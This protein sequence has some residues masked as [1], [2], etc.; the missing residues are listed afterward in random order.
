MVIL[1]KATVQDIKYAC[2]HFHYAKCTPPHQYAYSVYNC[3]NE[4]CGCII[5]SPG[6]CYRIACPF[7][8]N[9]GQVC[10]L[11]RVAL[12]GKQNC[13]SECVAAALKRLRQDA[14]QIKIVVSFADQNQGHL[15]IIYQ[16]TNWIYLGDTH[17][18]DTSNKN[19]HKP[20]FYVI[21]GIKM[22]PRSVYS[23]GW[24]QNLQWLR[25]NVD[26]NANAIKGLPKFKYIYVFDKKLRKKWSEKSRSYPKT[27]KKFAPCRFC[28]DANEND[29][30]FDNCMGSDSTDVA[31]VNTNRNFI[32]IELDKN[33]F[34]VAQARINSACA[35]KENAV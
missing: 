14:P 30:A 9:N 4:W 26:P 21:N 34:D 32:G 31:C 2:T 17:Q 15:G 22:H 29:M 23:K 18:L 8:L 10:E 5:F 13:T 35:E 16:A 25:E 12:N 28:A 1:T 11:V 7:D 24:K 20:D 27:V 33:Y 6:S 19:G 3:D